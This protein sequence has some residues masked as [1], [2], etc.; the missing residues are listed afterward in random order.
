MVKKILFLFLMM[1]ASFLMAQNVA[2][3][4]TVTDAN[5]EPLIG[6]N[7]V[8]KGTSTGAITD[9]NGAF[10]VNG[11]QGDVLVFTYIGMESQ[12]IAFRGTPLRVSMKDDSQALDEVVVVGYGSQKKVNLTG[13]VATVDFSDETLS[14]PVTTV[15]SALS[16]MVA[17]LN[18]MQT[19]SK[20]NSESSSIKIRGTGT[21]NDS[22]PLI[23][24]D[25][26]EMDLNNVNPND[27][28]SI[29]VL[30]DAASCAIYGNRGANG[31]ILVTTKKGSDGKINVSY[32]GKFSYNTPA[33]LNRMVSNYADYMEFIN[34]ASDNAGEASV[35]AQTTIDQWREAE[36]NPNGISE[37]GYPNYVAFPN[38]DWYDAVYNPKWMQEH[39]ITLTGAEKRTRYSLSAT[40]INN[41][42]LVVNSGMKKYYM[43]S[44]IE[45]QVTNFLA[46]GLNAWGYHTDQER[47]D[48][49][50]LNGLQMQKSTPGTYPYYDGKYG[51]PEAL[52]EDPVA[53]NPAYFLNNSDGYY[54]TTKFFVN[55]Y[56]KIDF[57]KDFHLTSNF[58]YD[59]YRAEHLWH[60][61]DYRER[62][63][64][65]RGETMN[66]PP[67][68]DILEEYTVKSYYDGNQS[69]K[70]TTTLNWEHLFAKKHDVNVLLGY[71]EY[72][73][74][75]RTTDISKKGMLDTS[76]ID[77]DA[78]TEPDYISGGSTE[79]SSRSWFGRVSYAYESRYL[80][81]INARYD[82]SSRF[83]PENR[84]GFF[85]SFSAGWRISEESFMKG[86]SWLDNLKLRVSWGQLG[87]NSIGNYEWQA[88]YNTAPHYSFGGLE[89][90][91]IGMGSFANYNLEWETTT[92]TNVGIDFTALKNRFSG[93]LEFYN[94]LTDGILY[95]PTLSP[96]LSGF[97]SPRQ[98]IAEVT[99][100]GVELT[101]SW[102]D[103]I[104]DFSY[105]ISGNFSYNKNEV[106]K[107]K[108]KLERGWS[109]NTYYTN[110]GEV[111]TG[112]LQRIVE[113][114]MINEF[115]VLNIYNGDAS[116]FNADG[117]VN[118]HGGPKDGMI[119]TEGDMKW[120][121]AMV[122][123][124][125]T[126]YPK[127]GI[128]KNKIWYGDIIYADTDGDGIYGDEDDKDFQGYNKTP[129]YYF[130][131]QASAFWKG[132]DFSMNWSGAAGFK[133]NWYQTGENSNITW[134]G[135][136]VGKDIAYDHY[137]Y[138]PEN[139][140]DPRTNTTSKNPRLTMDKS[141]QTSVQG[142]HIL[143]NGNYLKLKNLTIG[144]T[145]PKSLTKSIYLE[146]VRFY[147]SGENLLTITKF[148]G[149]DPEMMSGTGY[150]PMR[151]YAFGVNVTF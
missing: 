25:G 24:V 40:Y 28:A 33:K 82:G 77:F 26:M 79:F 123:A 131:L 6:V 87:N 62:F 81:E 68:S 98:N 13:S 65:Q 54:K 29:S 16:G 44:N 91:G 9:L 43:R 46:V 64:F 146:N 60:N 47:N 73:K 70:N 93:T 32:S 144:Y 19:S 80:L 136:G 61:S 58:Y 37:S 104:R 51:S 112:T 31:V 78:L 17:G 92:V 96:T 109:Q 90:P 27:V 67:T 138:D 76:L 134:F 57:L 94:K 66:T 30:K 118:P 148:D 69:W 145:L 135:Y 1:F 101:L 137:Y 126:F 125:Y 117:G 41:P 50:A 128:G 63:S 85:P 72:R 38:T 103:R 3:T 107:Y 20:P 34:E 142:Q 99:N 49:D 74:W 149:I 124:G 10:T 95:N 143:H 116:Y 21:L 121:E 56:I 100:R 75:S 141:A 132:F 22:S 115:Y 4:G 89:V 88:T 97:G 36:K 45:S 119:R 2:I 151:Q 150:A 83:S 102:N 23:L 5:G 113:G 140:S 133:I 14:R 7:V 111:S 55:P 114:H 59:H 11:K 53:A 120:L 48:V 35:F 105:S 130:G 52:E 139:P 106:T 12:E 71:E 15:A 122:A 39:S 110:I 108:G 8:V 84:W 18:V 147:V 129:K 127:Q 86:L 42:G